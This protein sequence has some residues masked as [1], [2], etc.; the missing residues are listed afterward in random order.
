MPPD[1]R[2][3]RVNDIIL[4]YWDWGGSGPPAVLVHAT[5]LH[6]RVWDPIAADLSRRYRVLAFEQRGHGDSDKPLTEY[7][8][9]SFVRD[10][11]GFLDA[12][13][14]ER[15]IGVGHSSGGATIAY[16]EA[17]YPGSFSRLALI[18]PVIQVPT[19]SQRGVA[20]SGRSLVEQ[21]R[22]KRTVWDSREQLFAT[23]RTRPAFQN[24]REDVLQAYIQHGTRDLP[25]GGIELKCPREIEAQ[26]YENSASLN[27]FARLPQIID[28]PVLIMRGEPSHNVHDTLQRS[29][30][31]VAQ[32]LP[33]GRLVTVPGAG[34]FL[35]QEKPE[36]VL[37]HLWRF[38]DEA[39]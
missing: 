22:R 31:L 24:W 14:L 37:E 36:A 13:G 29:M 17:E 19:T 6:G 28:V 16:C 3:I 10:V 32:A 7:H 18:E 35:P 33:K 4:H 11:K 27:T 30:E 9:L 26:V 25:G 1:S 23:Y 5:S 2:F 39:E 8:W 34:H 12:L 38:L 21:A 20:Q 15:P